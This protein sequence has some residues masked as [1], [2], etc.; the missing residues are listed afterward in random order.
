MPI[1]VGV[2][3]LDYGAQVHVPAFKEN[4]R[5]EVVAVASRVAG[6]AETFA[7]ESGIARWYTDP[8]QL[9]HSDLDLVSIATPPATHSGYAVM[10]LANRRHVLAEVA[11]MPSTAD[12]R[13]VAESAQRVKRVGVAAFV[14]RFT[15]LLR[16]ITDLLKQGLI[17]RPRLMTFDFLSNF[18]DVPDESN[19][20]IWDADNGGGVLAGYTAHALDLGLHWFGPVREVEAT[21]ATLTSL[22]LPAGLKHAADDTGAV[23]LHFESGVLGLFR[24]SGVTALPRTAIEVHGTEGS[25][26]ITGFGDEASL[27]R[28][29]AEAPETLFPPVAYLEETRGHSG[30]AGAFGIFLEHLAA[31]ITEHSLSPDLPTFADG[32]RVTRVIDA[33]R[34]AAR[35]KRRVALS[36]I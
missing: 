25:L 1:R 13:L 2:I 16:H 26:L 35:E 36:E 34:L 23:T 14:L 9:I 4:P 11:F 10:A 5:Y 30:L 27:L 29:G 31:A 6:R 32:L 12:A 33:A 3:G 28:M 15:P 7:R 17:G 22:S 21:L 20:W 24:H 18:L 19:R 8:R